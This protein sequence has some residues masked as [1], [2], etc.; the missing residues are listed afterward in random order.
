MNLITDETKNDIVKLNFSEAK[1]ESVAGKSET[2]ENNCLP[3]TA[4]MIP[5][6]TRNTK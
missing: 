1:D 6:T 5:N 3:L 2:S 4:I